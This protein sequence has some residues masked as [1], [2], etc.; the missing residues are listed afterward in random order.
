[1]VVRKASRSTK[2]CIGILPSGKPFEPFKASTVKLAS[3]DSCLV[4]L[5]IDATE[6]TFGLT[7]GVPVIP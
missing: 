1:M 4:R 6:M 3:V 7:E 2:E 5:L